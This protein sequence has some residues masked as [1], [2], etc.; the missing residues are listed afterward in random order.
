MIGWLLFIGFIMVVMFMIGL[1]V[2]KREERERAEMEVQIANLPAFIPAVRFD[3]PD[4]ARSLLLDAESNQFALAM[5]REAP[6]LYLFDQLVAVDV[7]R[8]GSSLQKT[9]RVSQM[10]GAAVGG[11]LLGPV[12]LLIGGLTGTKRNEELVKRLSLK[13]YTNDLEKPVTEVIFFDSLAGAKPT[14]AGV[15]A[16]ATQLEE[17]YGRFRTILQANERA[18]SAPVSRSEPR[19]P[20]D[21]PK[22]GFGRRRG[23]V[24]PG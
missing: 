5:P 13:V 3:Q 17:W 2:L 18:P 24:L 22:A 15:M 11:V 8:N 1:P 7:E 23:L 21:E 9:N 14:H 6:R 12:G 20:Q 16:A 4:K 10:M 19:S